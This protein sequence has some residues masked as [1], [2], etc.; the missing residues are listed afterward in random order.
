MDDGGCHTIVGL[1]ETHWIGLSIFWGVTEITGLARVAALT[2]LRTWGRDRCMA[3]F[4]VCC[5]GTKPV[6][7]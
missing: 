3:G 7:I 6:S 5:Y 1:H 2:I 4:Y